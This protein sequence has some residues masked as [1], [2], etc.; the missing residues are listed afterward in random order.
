[1][2]HTIVGMVL[3]VMIAIAINKA[4]NFIMGGDAFEKQDA[5]KWEAINK[6]VSD[7][8]FNE[9]VKEVKAEQLKGK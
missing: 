6:S 1:M 3:F 8:L 2:I 9:M 7:R 5:K 4:I